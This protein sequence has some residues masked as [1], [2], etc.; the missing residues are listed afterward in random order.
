MVEVIAQNTIALQQLRS[1][2]GTRRGCCQERLAQSQG[3]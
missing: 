1:G 3:I 2:T